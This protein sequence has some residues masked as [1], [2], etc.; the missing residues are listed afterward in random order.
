MLKEIVEFI[1]S[2]LAAGFWLYVLMLIILFLEKLVTWTKQELPNWGIV[3]LASLIWN[4]L[5]IWLR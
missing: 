1:L 5:V 2:V 4:L 3:L